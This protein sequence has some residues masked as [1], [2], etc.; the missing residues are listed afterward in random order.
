MWARVSSAKKDAK[1][2]LFLIA[3]CENN[4][5]CRCLEHAN[6]ASNMDF[7]DMLEN[8]SDLLNNAGFVI[9]VKD[10]Y[11]GLNTLIKVRYRS[12]KT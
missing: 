9:A 5:V 8:L 4:L 6:L 2:K 12:I 11:D 1:S 7:D 10:A 3:K